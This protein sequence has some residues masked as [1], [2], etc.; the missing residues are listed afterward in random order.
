MSE[1]V[2][3]L[4]YTFVRHALMAALLASIL[5]GVIGSFV[6]VKRLVFTSGGLSH[7]AFGG[8]G[9]AHMLGA[10]P[11]FGAMAAACVCG[12][13]LGLLGSGR[14]RLHDA[15]IGALWAV[16]MALGVLF[17]HLT[18]GYAPD[19]MAYL[20]GDIL[21]VSS[22]ALAVTAGLEIVVLGVI[23]WRFDEL[24]AVCFD[25]AF[26]RVQGIDVRAIF[27]AL[28]LLISISV[29]LL[30]QVVGIIL[31]IALLSLPP[32]LA[33]RLT[34]SF[35]G[36]L[37]GSVVAG[38]GMTFLGLTLAY[39]YDLPAGPTIILLGAASLGALAAGQRLWASLSPAPGDNA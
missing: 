28:M 10:P 29:V 2:D 15:P 35:R 32:L 36:L 24:V 6:V 31:V 17:V 3:A 11:A 39:R 33:L 16:G 8:I 20:F 1:L 13:I 22:R 26:A 7:A 37:A 18:P 19:L 23:I 30:I 9:L 5:C 14:S 34:Q 21:S 25:E 12:L 27:C 38:G 4:S